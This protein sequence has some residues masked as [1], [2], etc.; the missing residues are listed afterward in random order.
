MNTKE[1]EIVIQ[2]KKKKPVC[3]VKRCSETLTLANN[4]TCKDSGVKF[5][6]KHRF[7]TDDVCNKKTFS[8]SETSSRWND[9]FMEV[10]SMRKE[11]RL[12]KRNNFCFIK[13]SSID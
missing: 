4:L 3:P 2:E 7:P 11:Q 1:L 5:C 10:L 6:L 12:W 9:M 13:F 8:N